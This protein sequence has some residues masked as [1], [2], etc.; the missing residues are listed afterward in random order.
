MFL[1]A[2][3]KTLW[4]DPRWR[5]AIAMASEVELPSSISWTRPALSY[6]YNGT[7]AAEE[8]SIVLGCLRE[9]VRAVSSSYEASSYEP[10]I[11]KSWELLKASEP[12]ALDPR[13]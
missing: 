6:P 5:R 12:Q 1:S 8:M 9:T 10:M 13:P 2:R 11:R 4:L 7:M 3:L